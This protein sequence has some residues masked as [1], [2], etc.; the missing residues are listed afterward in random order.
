M[1]LRVGSRRSDLAR[2]QASQA[3]AVLAE[4]R[5]EIEVEWVWITTSGDRFVDRPLAEIGGK[6]LFIKEIEAALLDGSIDLAI[7]SGKDL[8][9]RLP[10]E[11]AIVATPTRAES[12]DVWCSLG[13]RP[14]DGPMRVGTGSLRRVLQLKRRHPELELVPIRGNVPTRLGRIG[15]D[16]DAVILAGAGLSRLGDRGR[17]TASGSTGCC[18]RARRGRWRSNVAATTRGRRRHCRRYMTTKL[19]VDLR[20]SASCRRR[21]VATAFCRSR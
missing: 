17:A 12:R 4:R 15:Q 6:G 9:A 21:L 18:R 11:L 7:H 10:D 2:A 5:P 19:G 20:P 16:L 8:P 3:M 14:G 13:A 1:K